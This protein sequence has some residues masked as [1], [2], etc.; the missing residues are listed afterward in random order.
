M[1]E[2]LLAKWAADRGL[3]W[4]SRSCGV[5]A[6][7]F[8]VVPAEVYQ[9][10]AASGITRFEHIPQLVSREILEW[11]DL[12][13]ALTDEHLEAVLDRYPEFTQKVQVL[14]RYAGLA[15]PNIE[16][17]I[18]QKQEV[19]DACLQRIRT[20]LEALMRKTHECQKP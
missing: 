16:D 5:A 19:Y 1:A 2:R 11:S 14:G 10:L 18:G 13:L 20:A 8:F 3:G 17:P 12:A 4:E 6:E 15:E 7:R 9:A